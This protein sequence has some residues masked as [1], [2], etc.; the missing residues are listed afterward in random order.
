MIQ[1][2]IQEKDNS[3]STAVKS[4]EDIYQEYINFLNLCQIIIFFS[5]VIQ[6]AH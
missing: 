5:K 6:D 4:I 1:R 2:N 3:S